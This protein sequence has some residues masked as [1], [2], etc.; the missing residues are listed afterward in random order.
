[1]D[2]EGLSGDLELLS[3]CGV[4][5]SVEQRTQLQSSLVIL[6]KKCK[7]QQVQLW[8]V[9]HGVSADYFIA[10]GLGRDELGDRKYLYSQDCKQ[11]S[12]LPQADRSLRDKC[13]QLQ[14]RFT[15]RPEHVHEQQVLERV[16]DGENAQETTT[17]V[18]VQ[19]VDRLAAVVYSIQQDSAAVPKGA[20]MQTHDGAVVRNK[21]FHGLSLAEASR[22][23]YYLH[24]S[25]PQSSSVNN[26]IHKLFLY[27]DTVDKDQPPG[28]WSVTKEQGGDTVLLR[29]LFWPGQVVY[30]KPQTSTFGHFYSGTGEKTTD[31]L[32]M[33]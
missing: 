31:L 21:S 26:D 10:V 17:T 23:S 19:E 9:I 24:F 7:F 15:G 5:L 11:W 6:R 33:L 12:Q 25:P 8:G 14:G 29:N 32:F 18:E 28:C 2:A 30:H 27:Q 3:C 4:V 1:M 22:C 13:A 16:E 20:Y